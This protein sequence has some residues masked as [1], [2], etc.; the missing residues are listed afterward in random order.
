MSTL[1]P[2]WYGFESRIGQANHVCSF[3]CK[4]ITTIK[5]MCFIENLPQGIQQRSQIKY[6]HKKVTVVALNVPNIL[7]AFNLFGREALKRK[8][9]EDSD[10]FLSNRRFYPRYMYCMFYI[11]GLCRHL[12][13]FSCHYLIFK[14]LNNDSKML[15]NDC[16][17]MADLWCWWVWLNF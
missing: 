2:T 10:V 16:I 12:Y 15:I 9:K 7:N 8:W 11:F 6:A 13:H 17:G 4:I 3:R 14:M 1:V 5:L